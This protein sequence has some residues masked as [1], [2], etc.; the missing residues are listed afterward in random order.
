MKKNI[1]IVAGEASG[2]LYGSEIAQNLCQ[3][4]QNIHC[5]GMGSVKMRNAGVKLLYDS[6]NI[7]VIGIWEVIKHWSDIQN[8]L[9]IL[10]EDI[11]LHPPD[12]LLL[13]DYQEFNIKLAQFAKQHGIKVL[14]YVSPQVWAWR[15]K[16]I[17][18]FINRIDMMA[19]LF[20]FEVK[21]YQDAGIPVRYVGH[22][23]TLKVKPSSTKQA[24]LAQFKLNSDKPIIAL[25]PGSRHSEIS[26]ILPILL[27]AAKAIQI[28]HPDSQFILPVANAKLKPAIHQ[29]IEQHQVI[30]SINDGQSYDVIACSTAVIVA[31]GTATLEVALLQVPMAIVYKI[32]AL[33]YTILKRLIKVPF[34]GLANIVAENQVA[35]EFIQDNA[36]PEAIAAEICRLIEDQNYRSHCQ[37]KLKLVAKK[38]GEIDGVTE[39]TQLVLEML[40]K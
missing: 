23:L 5:V 35:L 18:K 27:Q 26:R 24:L 19:V 7:A 22:P 2:D 14:F 25:L 17:K 30:V 3:Q 11:I 9:Q 39:V 12:L 38:L 33:S 34:V 15:R 6:A 29:L 1:M 13:I 37:D 8:A 36:K 20:P 28:K 10:K 40:E 4:E 32:S 21:Y 31:S 16:R